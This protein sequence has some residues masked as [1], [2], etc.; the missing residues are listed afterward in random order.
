MI[1]ILIS[2]LRVAV[3]FCLL[4][5]QCANTA[6]SPGNHRRISII[7]ICFFFFFLLWFLE[8]N[9][10]H[11]NILN[12]RPVW[13]TFS[14]FAVVRISWWV[15]GLL[16]FSP[17][18]GPFVF[19]GGERRLYFILQYVTSLTLDRQ[20][21]HLLITAAKRITYGAFE[22]TRRPGLVNNDLLYVAQRRRAALSWLRKRRERVRSTYH[23]ILTYIMHGAAGY[24]GCLFQRR[25][26]LAAFES[27]R[28]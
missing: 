9:H 25:A 8:L 3:Y 7:S 13:F 14:L 11:L 24:G 22:S 27:D 23:D 5:P 12:R 21:L 28:V 6:S 19:A 2:C 10:A 4:W 16:A 1:W 18:L 17:L 20:N 15:G 26:N